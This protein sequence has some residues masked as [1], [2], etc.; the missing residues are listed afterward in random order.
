MLWRLSFFLALVLAVG[1]RPG[2]AEGVGSGLIMPIRPPM[3]GFV[4]L[5]QSPPPRIIR[6]PANP[7]PL[8]AAVAAP[9]VGAADRD[10][11]KSQPAECAGLH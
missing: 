11:H 6:D 10:R 7:A 1:P 9:R 5:F 3:Q 2:A 8:N 4:S